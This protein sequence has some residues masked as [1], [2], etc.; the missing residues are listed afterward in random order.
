MFSLILTLLIGEVPKMYACVLYMQFL[1]HHILLN[2]EK[3]DK[4]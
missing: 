3:K 4:S 1:I 2:L